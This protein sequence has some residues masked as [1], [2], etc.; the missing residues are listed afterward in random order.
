MGLIDIC[1]D[2]HEVS[3]NVLFQIIKLSSSPLFGKNFL[4]VDSYGRGSTSTAGDAYKQSVFS[5]LGSAY[6]NYGLNIAFVDLGELLAAAITD[7]ESFG[8]EDVGP[9][10]VDETTTVGQ[11]SS[12][13]STVFYI[14]E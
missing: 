14:S 7:P 9:C 5:G 1:P 13:N 12:P 11:C 3:S 4:V 2:L 10:T 8:Y 6:N